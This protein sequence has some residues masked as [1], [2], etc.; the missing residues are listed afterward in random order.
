MNF[1]LKNLSLP[2]S[3]Q[4]NITEHIKSKF[5]F[6]V[7][8]ND[9]VKIVKRAIDARKKNH[10]KFIYTL[11][12]QTDKKIQPHN[13]IVIQ[14]E[15]IKNEVL[16]PPKP[17]TPFII[18]MGPAG[19]FTALQL[20]KYGYKPYLFDRGD[21]IDTRKKKIDDFWQTKNLDPNSNVQFGEGGAGAFS[22]G[23]LTARTHNFETDEVFDYLIKFGADPDISINALPHIGTDNLIILI[24]K[25]KNFLSESGCKFFYNHKLNDITIEN[26]KVKQIKINDQIY[27]PEIVVLAVGNGARDVFTLCNERNIQIENKS[28]AVGLRIEHNIDYINHTFYGD[29]NEF[30]ITGPATYKLTSKTAYSFCMCPGGY[31]IPAHCESDGQVVNGMSFSARDNNFSN[32]AIVVGVNCEQFLNNPLGGIEFQRQLEKTFFHKFIAPAQNVKDFMNNKSSKNLFK[33]SYYHDVT[34]INFHDKLPKFISEAITMAMIDFDKKYN[35]F[36]NNGLFIGVE[37]RTSSPIRIIRNSDTLHCVGITNLY[38]AGEGSGYAGGI[39]SSAVDGI[40]IAKAIIST[41]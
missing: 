17:F 26:S 40:K 39:I 10:L 7:S 19:L 36:I 15:V 22:D 27:E 41:A 32:S 29:K 5:G 14:F 35:G 31:V 6:V 20:V 21:D 11:S 28:F 33:N 3:E 38:P 34:P 12:L 13:D 18:G 25:I 16:K 30:D 2:I 4:L 9:C 24:K 23:K 37:T 1:L 8:N